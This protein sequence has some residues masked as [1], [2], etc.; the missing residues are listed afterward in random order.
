MDYSQGFWP[1][2]SLQC[3]QHVLV[4]P[5]NHGLLL[6][7]NEELFLCSLSILIL[8]CGRVY[9]LQREGREGGRGGRGGEGREGREGREGGRR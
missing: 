6:L 1:H 3:L 4:L 5:P 2:L 7:L 8:L 9:V